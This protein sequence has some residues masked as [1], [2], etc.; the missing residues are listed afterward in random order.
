MNL[1]DR[2]LILS[3]ND[4]TNRYPRQAATQVIWTKVSTDGFADLL[5][6]KGFALTTPSMMK[7]H[8]HPP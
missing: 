8:L 5:L 2:D 7:I 4:L 3:G 1:S 6:G